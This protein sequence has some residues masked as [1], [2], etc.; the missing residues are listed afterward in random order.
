[1]A[2]GKTRK[3]HSADFKA[4]LALEAVLPTRALIRLYLRK[5]Q[6]VARLQHWMVE[7]TREHAAGINQEIYCA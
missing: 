1:M 6:L 4:K 5:N 2:E 3:V 7:V